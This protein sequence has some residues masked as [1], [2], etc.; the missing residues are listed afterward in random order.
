MLKKWLKWGAVAFVVWYIVKR[1]D[2]AALVVQG[3]LNGLGGAAD[4]IS[5]FM[6]SAIP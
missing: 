5:T 4:S 1:P 3:T 6:M 2:G